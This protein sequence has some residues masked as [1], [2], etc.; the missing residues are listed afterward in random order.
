MRLNDRSVRR[1]RWGAC[2]VLAGL[3][4]AVLGGDGVHAN[5]DES[6]RG[7]LITGL[8]ARHELWAVGIGLP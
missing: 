6:T 5:S 8:E 7:F 1:Y 3:A 2:A 4:M